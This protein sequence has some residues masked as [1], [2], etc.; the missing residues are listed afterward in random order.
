[1]ALVRPGQW[2]LTDVV[3]VRMSAAPATAGRGGSERRRGCRGS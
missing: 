1:M 2:T 3:D